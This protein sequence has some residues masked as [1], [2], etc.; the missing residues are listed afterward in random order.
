MGQMKMPNYRHFV[1]VL[2]MTF[3]I[4][5][6]SACQPLGREGIP[7]R[8][9]TTKSLLIDETPWPQGWYIRNTMP[10]ADHHGAIERIS[11]TI[12]HPG[13]G[14]DA[15]EEIYRYKYLGSAE[16]EYTRQREVFFQG[17]KLYGPFTV[18]EQLRA[19]LDFADEAYIACMPYI[20]K[21]DPF[22]N[23]HMLARYGEFIVRFH[24]EVVP[25][26]LSYE[27]LAEI[28]SQLDD[29]FEAAFE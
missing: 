28:L 8:N 11:I 10:P 22:D 17:S 12:G 23:C 13:G 25:G 7:Q 24:T 6:F 14:G 27:Q 16:R 3:V 21:G 19:A 2:L 15:F 5:C 4:S 29:K 18:N 1:L 20:A 9:L 26:F